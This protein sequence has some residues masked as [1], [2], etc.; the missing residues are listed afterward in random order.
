MADIIDKLELLRA[1]W[2]KNGV[3]YGIVDEAIKTI[4]ALKAA[5]P[6]VTSI[7]IRDR[8]I[9]LTLREAV[10]A[11]YCII[12]FRACADDSMTIRS[13]CSVC[14][15]FNYYR[16]CHSISLHVLGDR[17]SYAYNSRSYGVTWRC[18]AAMPTPQEIAE[19]KWED[20]SPC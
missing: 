11:E 17:D 19:A 4:E 20:G 10:E 3:N 13:G 5:S 16:D 8:L 2:N 14:R 15:V 9:P 6:N 1:R 18:W 12:E 7:T